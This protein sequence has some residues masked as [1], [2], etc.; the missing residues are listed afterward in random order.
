MTEPPPPPSHAPVP[1]PPT[2]E[3]DGGAG[4]AHGAARARVLLIDDSE[5]VRAAMRTQLEADG[6]L[7]WELPSAVGA[8][9]TALR[10]G[11]D[12]VLIDVVLPGT[13]GD[14]IVPI[15]R[16]HPQLADIAVILV[17][18]EGEGELFRLSRECR[19]DAVVSKARLEQLLP[20]VNRVLRL[21]QVAADRRRQSGEY[22]SVTPSRGFGAVVPGTPGSLDGARPRR[23]P[24]D[25]PP[26][27]TGPALSQPGASAP[28]AS[29][30]GSLAPPSRGT[31]PPTS[32]LRRTGESSPRTPPR[33]PRRAE[34]RASDVTPDSPTERENERPTDRP[35]RA[36]P[37]R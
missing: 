2:A 36:R 20:T 25:P 31:V 7:V 12:L 10:H 24:A 35:P 4:G 16:N 28:G 18:G 30:P 5:V 34:L 8:T 3:G 19:V 27:A 14:R 26:S 11:V 6:K 1:A 33:D 23:S 13:T 22:R 15:F 32:G 37:G 9:R 29:P 21:R 17:S